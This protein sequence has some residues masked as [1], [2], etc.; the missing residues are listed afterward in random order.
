MITDFAGFGW[1]I[2][3]FMLC[4]SGLIYSNFSCAIEGLACLVRPLIAASRFNKAY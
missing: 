1:V 4:Y 2:W 3:L